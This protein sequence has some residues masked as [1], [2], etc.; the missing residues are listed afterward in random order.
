MGLA[1]DESVDGL[2]KL[3]N[4]GVATYIEPGLKEFLSQFEGVL[5][6]HVTMGGRSGFIVKVGGAGE[7]G[8]SGCSSGS[9]G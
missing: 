4:N 7:C 6:D 3:E 8:D 9:C 5:I 1:L 2:E